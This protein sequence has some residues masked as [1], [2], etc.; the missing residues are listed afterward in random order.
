MNENLHLENIQPEKE[1]TPDKKLN[2]IP[3]EEV[4]SE[5]KEKLLL[6]NDDIASSDNKNENIDNVDYNSLTKEQLVAVL[7]RL[8]QDKPV[9][10]IKDDVEVIKS[11]FY[12]KHN[13]E[14]EQL[15]KIFIESGGSE[16]DFQP[17]KDI[18]EE[19]LKDYLEKYKE[20]KQAYRK[21]LE[22]EKEEN[23]K[24]KLEVIE[25]IKQLVHKEESVNKT[26][27]E[28]RA[29]QEKWRSIG[30]V[31]Q[32]KM[33]EL[34]ET[35]N[36]HVDNFYNYIK[37]NRELRDLDL[38]K[39]LESK[40]EL[41]EKAESLML[42]TNIP[43]AFR[44]LQDLHMQ[45]KEIGP[46]P[47]DKKDE[48]WERFR[49]ISSKINQKHQEYL[50]KKKEEREKNLKA[51]QVLCEQVEEINL[52]KYNNHQEWEEKTNEILEIQKVWKTIGEVPR[53]ENTN[54]YKRFRAACDVFFDRKKE[55]YEGLKEDQVQNLQKKIEICVQAE[56]I[57]DSTDWKKTTEE[58]FKLQDQWKTIG[59]V[60]KKDSEA[61]WKRFRAACDHF[62]NRKE[63][64]F[65]NKNKE[66]EA[67]VVKKQELIKK[68]QEFEPANNIEES[69]ELLKQYQKEFTE[70]GNVPAKDRSRL[71]NEFKKAINAQF[72]KLNISED[73]LELYKFRSY[74]NSLLESS[75]PK[76]SL[77][78]ERDKLSKIINKRESDLALLENNMGFFNKSAGAKDILD[79]MNK[80]IEDGKAQLKVLKSKADMLNKAIQSLK[81][82]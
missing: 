77:L 76:A 69:L 75:N 54:I 48:I 2:N 46:V 67:N 29:L 55:F 18:S 11:C 24:K 56:S 43:A 27:E 60:A 71:Y 65:A 61:V 36:L 22:A 8:I 79:E 45:W 82:N 70:I 28:F 74:I 37:I 57:Q 7:K 16:E 35:Y 53:A 78:S 34:L 50:E 19:N 32:N 26:F 20:L 49:E 15:K 40:I 33:K 30:V 47:A 51:K 10:E 72:E 12:K 80:K 64:Y 73:K 25:A 66:I 13:A 39:N 59:P 9:N 5:K 23:Y 14:L 4:N 44:T 68:V 58:F 42:E 6:N 62:F 63:Q 41:C 17:P 38:K 81:T 21:N 1:E 52:H 3:A 31:P